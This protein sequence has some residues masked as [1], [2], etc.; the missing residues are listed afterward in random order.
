MVSLRAAFAADADH[1]H[2]ADPESPVHDHRFELGLA[3]GL[4]Y[5]VSESEFTAGLHLHLV[6]TAWD[7]SWS[8]GVGYER[9]FDEHAHNTMSAVVQYRLTNSWNVIIAPG[10]TFRD[11]DPAAVDP[12]VHV[13]TAYEFII[14][15]FHAGPS[16]EL[17]VDPDDVHLTAGVHLGLGF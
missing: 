6:A 8:F 12:S 13:E 15:E 16:L 3:P 4:V 2:E 9:L 14:G 1:A 10:F 17:A 11:E 5:L 7:S